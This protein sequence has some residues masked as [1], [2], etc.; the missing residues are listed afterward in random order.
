MWDSSISDGE[1]CPVCYHSISSGQPYAIIDGSPE[2]AKKYHP[3][4]LEEWF[5]KSDKGIMSREQVKTYT[6]DYG[7]EKEVVKIEPKDSKPKYEVFGG[8]DLPTA[9]NYEDMYQS[10]YLGPP[11]DGSVNYDLE[12]NIIVEEAPRRKY[13]Y[14]YVIC[15]GIL[16]ILLF[17]LLFIWYMS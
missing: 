15:V 6:I 17:V 10:A 4:C 11:P 3:E 8:S 16:L 12:A 1:E 13:Y 5:N 14:N 2:G 9:P 7:E